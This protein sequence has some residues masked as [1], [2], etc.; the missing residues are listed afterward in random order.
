[1][2]AAAVATVR[3]RAPGRINLA[4]EPNHYNDGLVLPVPL[5]LHVGVTLAPRDD[6]V[7][8]VRSA[9]YPG[10]GLVDLR[11]GEEQRRGHWTD[12][13]AGVTATL[14]ADGLP[15]RGFV[16]RIES[17]LPP[18]DGLSSST[19]L[20]VALLRALRLAF[21]LAL[22]DAAIARAAHRAEHDFVGAPVGVT[23]CMAVS[24]GRPSFALLL[25]PRTLVYEHVAI[26]AAAAIAVIGAGTADRRAGEGYRGRWAECEAA[27][28][29]LGV[30]SLRDATLAD[31]EHAGLP[32]PLDRRARHVVT[33]NAR[34]LDMVAALREGDLVR[35]GAVL[36][37]AHA[38]LQRDL[39]VSR[40]EIDAIVE[41]AAQDPAVLGARLASG[42]PGGAVIVL[43]R[44]DAAAAPAT[45]AR[46]C[47][48]RSGAQV[49]VADVLDAGPATGV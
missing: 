18:D 38:S 31:V 45:T 5:P 49:L 12:Y 37:A 34:V 22:D 41:A 1:M 10:D 23:D 33:E 20:T 25:D 42:G 40:P 11:I 4:G 46:R 13:V 28:R 35:C 3:A 21:N 6:R 44:R 7:V 24:L 36:A 39:E 43:M 14:L 48:W 26:P 9:S 17:R 2:P 29:A 15:V 47:A 19:A 30:A 27:A 16:A 8:R 32:P